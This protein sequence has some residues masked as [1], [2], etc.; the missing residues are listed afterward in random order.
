VVSVFQFDSDHYSAPDNV[1]NSGFSFEKSKFKRI[2][3]NYMV[4]TQWEMVDLLVLHGAGLGDS[5]N[6]VSFSFLGKIKLREKYKKM[7]QSAEIR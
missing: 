7:T 4:N 2:R 6:T 1:D 5:T 3:K